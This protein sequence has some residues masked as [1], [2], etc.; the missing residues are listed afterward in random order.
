MNVFSEDPPNAQGGASV[1]GRELA[2][3][4]CDEQSKENHAWMVGAEQSCLFM[5]VVS[6]LGR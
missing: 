5:A 1:A 4:G 6:L 3:V 2:I